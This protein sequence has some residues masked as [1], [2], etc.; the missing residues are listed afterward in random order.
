MLQRY[1][2]LYLSGAK[3]ISGAGTPID[4]DQQNSAQILINVTAITG[5][6]DI[7]VEVSMDGSA[8]FTHPDTAF[9]QFS[10][11]GKAAKNFHGLSR[12][13][14]LSYAVGTGPCTFTAD[15]TTSE[16]V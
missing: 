5:T 13:S 7:V 3:T 16:H 11:T 10:G 1:I 12:Y 8:W 15:I 6:L 2:P 14:R 4:N 9:S